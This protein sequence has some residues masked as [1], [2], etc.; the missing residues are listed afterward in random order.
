MNFLRN[1]RN[2]DVESFFIG[3]RDRFSIPHPTLVLSD[4]FRKD[5]MDRVNLDIMGETS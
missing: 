5:V 1:K 3:Y 4:G 2:E